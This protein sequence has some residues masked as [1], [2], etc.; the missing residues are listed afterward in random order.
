MKNK[1]ILDGQAFKSVLSGVLLIA[2]C[3][4]GD[5]EAKKRVR[6]QG[7]VEGVEEPALKRPRVLPQQQ[8]VGP[9]RGTPVRRSSGLQQ[10]Q[11]QEPRGQR[12]P[13][14]VPPTGVQPVVGQQQNVSQSDFIAVTM[15][16]GKVFANPKENWFLWILDQDVPWSDDAKAVLSVV[17]N[18]LSPVQQAAIRQH[19]DREMRSAAQREDLKK[20]RAA[21]VQQLPE[22]VVMQKAPDKGWFYNLTGYELPE[23][24][25]WQKFGAGVAATVM[26]PYLAPAIWS[27]G[28]LQAAVALTTTATAVNQIKFSYDHGA[29]TTAGAIENRAALMR[30]K[31]QGNQKYPTFKTQL[32]ALSSTTELLALGEREGDK[33]FDGAREKLI[34]ETMELMKK[35][36]KEGGKD[37]ENENAIN[38]AIYQCRQDNYD[39]DAMTYLDNL[40]SGA[41]KPGNMA[42]SQAYV[43]E[44]A[45]KKDILAKMALRE[46]ALET[47][48]AK[49]AQAIE[50]AKAAVTGAVGA[51]VG[52]AAAG[53]GKIAAKVAEGYAGGASSSSSS[54]VAPKSYPSTNPFAPK[55]ST[56][57]NPFSVNET[58]KAIQQPVQQQQP[59]STTPGP[60]VV[61]QPPASQTVTPVNLPK[62][63]T[64]EEK[65]AV[66]TQP[67]AQTP[68]QGQPAPGQ[69]QAGAA[70]KGNNPLGKLRGAGSAM[71]NAGLGSMGMSG[72]QEV[73]K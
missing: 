19:E 12:Q 37:L 22:T 48:E 36:S 17:R 53:A 34:A 31:L 61:T 62:Y 8:S 27:W 67:G 23:L 56:Q 33:I 63:P 71:W 6:E 57:I 55:P 65:P 29:L 30:E 24:S 73:K 28:G 35:L 15:P 3:I 14:V 9:R 32:E 49:R 5:V 60:K 59:A 50:E 66:T 16:D 47:E 58:P 41:K 51:V 64:L 54:A 68:Q 52:G 4:I 45:R 26:A 43:S 70:P 1:L 69:Q 72:S 25:G 46:K 38:D 10:R 21:M 40:E 44:F 11:I 7:V 39:K 20:Q 18:Q 42:R 2:L 13:I